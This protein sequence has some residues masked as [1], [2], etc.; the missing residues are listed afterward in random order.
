MTLT[1]ENATVQLV[2]KP[3][4]GLWSLYSRQRDGAF[5]EDARSGVAYRR[6]GSAIRTLED[7]QPME[8]VADEQVSSPHGEQRQIDLTVRPA[9]GTLSYQISFALPADH[10][11]LLWRIALQNTGSKPIRV[12]GLDLLRVGF[13]VRRVSIFTPGEFIATQVRAR[14]RYLGV[15]RP[16][17]RLGDPAFYANGWASWS[18]SGA[19][20]RFDQA[21]A[22]RLGFLRSPSTLNPWTNRSKRRGHFTSEMFGV[23]GDRA[24][25]S[26]IL[27]GFL[28]QRE[29]FGAVEA[30]TDP[31]LP[32]L[33]L[34]AQA[35]GVRLDPGE[36]L[37]SD[38]ACLSFPHLDAPDPL[39]PYLEA[40]SRE[41]GLP[42]FDQQV[43]AGWCSW[44]HFFGDLTARDVQQNLDAIRNWGRDL[45][46][47]VVQIDD[48]YQT[49]I[50]DWDAFTPEFPDGVAPLAAEI[51]DAGLTPGLWLAPFLVDPRS[52]LARKNPAWLLRGGLGLRASA[53]FDGSSRFY[54]A[55]DL[56]HPEALAY[57]AEAVRRAAHDW[58]FPYLKLDFLYAGALPGRHLDPTRTRAQVLRAGLAALREAAGEQTFLL[59]CGCP[60][61]PAVGLVD[62]MRIG[63]DVGP[64]WEPQYR[65]IRLFFNREPDIPSAENSLKGALARAALH[66]RW[67]LNDP[68]CVLL[69]PETSLTRAEVESMATVV[70]LTGG[71]LLASDHLPDLPPERLRLLQAMLPPIGRRPH[72]L[73]WFDSSP[74]ARLQ[75]DMDGPAG[76]WHLVALFNWSDAP[77]RLRLQANEFYLDPTSEYIAREFWSG[78]FHDLTGESFTLPEAP[79]HG[80]ALLA[81]RRQTHQRPQY[82]GSDLHIS[83]GLEVAAWQPEPD[84]LTVSLSRPGRA[85]GSVYLSLPD[86]PDRA[87]LAGRPVK[88]QAAGPQI[89][90]FPVAFQSEAPLQIHWKSQ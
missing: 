24:H 6:G 62:A 34:W 20:G 18:F 80:V 61:G 9:R 21:I 51:Q 19:Y 41:N 50:G 46:L 35:D 36:T 59:G 72:V 14:V 57:A 60:L 23:L 28:S 5:F 85:E 76:P 40:V 27:A 82:V 48:G 67:W 33:R 90:R 10:P 63:P 81:L 26:A 25:R 15:L 4:S 77:Q 37:A 56:T 47:D 87:T 43:P 53:G 31:Q 88:W 2:L 38:W 39:A 3:E 29:G 75:L 54:R 22:T 42:A 55:L 11:L 7:L 79:P 13:P 86:E 17:P 58:G 1:Y 74:P 16:H 52:R 45:P 71:L 66:R 65:G 49:Y 32:S 8:I 70:A 64:H 68:D 30:W 12:D 78:E 73:D 84:G 44:Y 83:Q 89:Y 69:R